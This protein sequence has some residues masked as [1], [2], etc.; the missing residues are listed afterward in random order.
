MAAVGS[1]SLAG[2]ALMGVLRNARC[3]PEAD[4]GRNLDLNADR[5]QVKLRLDR[6]RTEWDEFT[7]LGV[8][9]P[10]S[11]QQDQGVQTLRSTQLPLADHIH[12]SRSSW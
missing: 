3:D 1:G 9:V 6:D 12:Q 10:F 11:V 5:A 8:F 4:Q 2:S 7:L